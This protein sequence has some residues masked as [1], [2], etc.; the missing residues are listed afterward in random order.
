MFLNHLGVAVDRCARQPRCVFLI[1]AINY[2]ITECAAA[3]HDGEKS[4]QPGSKSCLI[5]L[6]K[7]LGSF[8]QV[9]FFDGLGDK[10]SLNISSNISVAID[11]SSCIS[12]YECY[13][14]E[15]R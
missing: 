2:I 13:N 12:N 1:E 9:V 7:F 3:N 4:M 14:N 6:L 5:D 10:L 15:A 8:L 11:I